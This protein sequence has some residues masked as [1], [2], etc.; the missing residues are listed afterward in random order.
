MTP[1]KQRSKAAAESIA[2][3]QEKQSNRPGLRAYPGPVIDGKWCDTTLVGQKSYFTRNEAC[4]IYTWTAEG[5]DKKGKYRQQSELM[6]QVKLDPE[7]DT[8]KQWLQ[9]VPIAGSYKPG[10]PWPAAS[11]AMAFNIGAACNAGCT[12]DET[13]FDWESD[14]KPNWGSGRDEHMAQG[15]ATLKWDGSVANASGARDVDLSKEL[16]LWIHGFMSTNV[17][18]M[19]MVQPEGGTPIFKARCDKAKLADNKVPGCVFSRYVPGYVINSAKAPAAAAHAWLL[20]QKTPANVGRDPLHPLNYLPGADRNEGN[21][22]PDKTNRD[23]VCNRS[24]PGTF[25]NHPDTGLFPELVATGGA[26]IVSCDEYAFN[27]TYQSGGMPADKGGTNEISHGGECVQTYATK[28]KL[29]D[30]LRYAAPTWKEVCGRSSMS[31][32]VNGAAMNRFGSVFAPQFR[33]LDHDSYWVQVPGLD[34]CDASG[35]TVKCE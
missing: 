35:A 24:G 7:G 5:E 27:A 21:V 34:D 31:Q 17:P 6:W 14:R 26:D 33:L 22:I 3:A 29:Y 12:D 1:E 2:R 25:T 8:I 11:G 32:W 23:K 4:L 30:D 16:P 19:V 20:Q 13:G 15:S 10:L 9:M 28:D 18:D